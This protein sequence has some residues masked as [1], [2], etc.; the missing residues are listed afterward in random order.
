MMLGVRLP[1]SLDQRLG[2]LAQKTHRPKSFYVKEALE[3]YL[4][5]NE[6]M[7]SALAD[8]EEQV[9]NGTSVTYSLEEIKRRHDLD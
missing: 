9:K 4:N 6:E 2:Q 7:F 3:A 8:Y 5:A 1:E